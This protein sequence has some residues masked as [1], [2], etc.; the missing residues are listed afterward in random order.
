[1]V[2]SF[3]YSS[4]AYRVLVVLTTGTGRPNEDLGPVASSRLRLLA[5]LGLRCSV[6]MHRV[7]SSGIMHGVL[8]SAWE[9]GPGRRRRK[10]L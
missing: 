1:V 2:A 10:C 5:S 7:P 9:S 6:E 3:P 8:L 4:D